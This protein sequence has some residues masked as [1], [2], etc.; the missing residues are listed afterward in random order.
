MVKGKVLRQREMEMASARND[1]V[2]GRK[3]KEKQRMIRRGYI[4]FYE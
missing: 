1:S 4:G 2:S 3:E